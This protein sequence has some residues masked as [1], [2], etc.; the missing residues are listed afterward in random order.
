MILLLGACGGLAVAFA[1]WERRVPE[2]I[3]PLVLY[4]HRTFLAASLMVLG[5]GAFMW[6]IN[7]YVPLLAQGALGASPAYSGAILLPF[8]L[9]TFIFSGVLGRLMSR[10]GRFR[11]QLFMGPAVSLLGLILLTHMN[12]IPSEGE[13]APILVICGLGLAL[14]NATTIA[15]Q[16][17]MPRRMMATALGGLQFARILGGAVM[18]NVFGAVMNSSVRSELAR[19][20][21]S[22]SPLRRVSPDLL[23]TRAVKISPADTVT[24][25]TAIGRAIPTVFYVVMPLAVVSFLA[26]FLVEHRQL[27]NTIGDESEIGAE[28]DRAGDR[29]AHTAPV[30]VEPA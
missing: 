26:A 1:V 16:N 3:V 19:S 7:T 30:P 8:G 18:L 21:P 11:W 22:G 25:H 10:T 29:S 15:V 6:S 27:R 12:P 28:L 17:V 4:R 13:L 23:I 20:L 2:P 24:V 9:S 14:G 5:Y